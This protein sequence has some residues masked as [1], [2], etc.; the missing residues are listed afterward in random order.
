M[1]YAKKTK[2]P[3]TTT[4]LKFEEPIIYGDY[5]TPYTTDIL[6]DLTDAKKG[7]RQKIYHESATAPTLP[8][9]WVNIGTTTYDTTKLN[10]IYAEYSQDN[11]VEYMIYN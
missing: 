2:Q 11:R 1:I 8:G 3:F 4:P 5:L 7:V 6:Q 9:G 10:I